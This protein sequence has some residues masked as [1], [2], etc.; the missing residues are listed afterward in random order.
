MVEGEGERI[1]TIDGKLS[2][3]PCFLRTAL[4]F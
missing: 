1:F 2:F 3:P 4:L